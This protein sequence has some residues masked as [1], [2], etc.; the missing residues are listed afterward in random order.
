MHISKSSV[1][2]VQP[3]PLPSWSQPVITDHSSSEMWLFSVSRKRSQGG[4]CVNAKLQLALP[5]FFFSLSSLSRLHVRL[6]LKFNC[7]RVNIL[8]RLSNISP[9]VN[10]HKPDSPRKTFIISMNPMNDPVISYLVP[11]MFIRTFAK[12]IVPPCAAEAVR[13]G[14]NVPRSHSNKLSLPSHLP[15]QSNS[16]LGQKWPQIIQTLL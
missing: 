5:F 1:A 8:G 11:A 6:S 4:S 12:T 9:T 16:D 13:R 10:L 15:H 2:G 14:D 3:T 7:T